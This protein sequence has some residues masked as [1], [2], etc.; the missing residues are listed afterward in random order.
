MGKKKE[1]CYIYKVARDGCLN[2]VNI[3]ALGAD[4]AIDPSEFLERDKDNLTPLYWAARNGQLSSVK[5][6][7]PDGITFPKEEF[8]CADD[9]GNS[10]FQ[11]AAKEGELDILRD[12]VPEGTVFEKTD[13]F[14][15]NNFGSTP[16]HWSMWHGNLN[17]VVDMIPQES[18]PLS[19][20]D[21]LKRDKEGD[22]LLHM[23]FCHRETKALRQLGAGKVFKRQDFLKPNNK[24]INPFQKAV[25][26]TAA[27][28]LPS[29]LREGE[30]M[31][32]CDLYRGLDKQADD[33][34]ERILYDQNGHK[35][36]QLQRLDVFSLK[37]LSQYYK[38][39]P[40][41]SHTQS[42]DLLYASARRAIRKQ[43]PQEVVPPFRVGGA[44]N[45]AC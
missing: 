27:A 15:E 43:M 23:A 45:S 22:T 18:L 8:M 42:F 4:D 26:Y 24:G 9:K 32:L 31:Q 16:I 35:M 38:E 28:A 20:A 10:A 39:R 7:L 19:R 41:N 3:E 11:Y 25:R 21:F 17:Q 44:R 6:I 5:R 29:L 33:K 36:K 37:T 30:K 34:R 1:H 12:L 40:A 13:F 2:A 14:N